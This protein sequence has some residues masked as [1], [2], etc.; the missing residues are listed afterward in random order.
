M[1]NLI[2]NNC[3]TYVLQLLDAI[4]TSGDKEFGTTL[5]IYERI[6]GPGK[7]ADLFPET[8]SAEQEAQANTGNTVSFAQ[9][10]MRVNTTQLDARQELQ[11]KKTS[12]ER[13]KDSKEE[14]KKKGKSNFFS[15]FTK[16]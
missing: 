8:E 13:G 5:A 6:T 12:G 15:R 4:K 7:V 1:Y 11:E 3:Q 9:Q 10:V 16:G 14:K 2:T